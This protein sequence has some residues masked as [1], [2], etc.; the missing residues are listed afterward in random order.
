MVDVREHHALDLR[1]PG[2]FGGGRF[3]PLDWWTN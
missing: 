1:G 3:D 2:Y